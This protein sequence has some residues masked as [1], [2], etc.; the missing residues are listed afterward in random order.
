MRF[1]NFLAKIKL[2]LMALHTFIVGF[3]KGR[4]TVPIITANLFVWNEK[5]VKDF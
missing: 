1:E 2:K 3:K 4:L 5:N